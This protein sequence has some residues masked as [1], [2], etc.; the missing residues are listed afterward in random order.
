V[1]TG[2]FFAINVI[3]GDLGTFDGIKTSVVGEV[4][5]RDGS[6]IEGLYA[7]GNDRESIMGGN[8][9]GAGITHGP[10]MTHGFVTGNHI[11]DKAGVTA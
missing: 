7:V 11:A 3:M 6:A 2:P 4:L 1:Q 5:K 9:P 10:N 8:Y